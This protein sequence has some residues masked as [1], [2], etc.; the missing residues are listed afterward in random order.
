MPLGR[1]GGIVTTQSVRRLAT[2]GQGFAARGSPASRQGLETVA[3]EALLAQ[4]EG[5]DRSGP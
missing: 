3:R 1:T 5:L 4:K 2:P